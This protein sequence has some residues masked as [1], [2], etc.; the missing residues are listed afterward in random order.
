MLNH[1][2]SWGHE[3][4]AVAGLLRQPECNLVNVYCV[5]SKVKANTDCD[6]SVMGMSRMHWPSLLLQNVVPWAFVCPL[7]TGLY[8]GSGP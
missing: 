2:E 4:R 1:R 3:L 5:P 8:L 7:L 6:P